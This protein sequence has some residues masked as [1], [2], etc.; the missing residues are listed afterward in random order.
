MTSEIIVGALAFL[1]T[2]IGAFSANKLVI[3]RIDQLELKVQKHNQ[4]IERMYEQEKR[5]E[6]LEE[7][8]SVA[9]H[10]IDDLE[11]HHA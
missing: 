11:S 10:R 9:N 5:T 7:K 3:Y 2:L 6:V 8:I 1:G 4:V